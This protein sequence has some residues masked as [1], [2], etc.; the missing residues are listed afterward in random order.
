MK[1]IRTFWF[2]TLDGCFGIV[3]GEDDVTG[4]RKAYCGVVAGDDEEADEARI[5]RGGSSINAHLLREAL[6]LLEPSDPAVEAGKTHE[7][8]ARQRR[9]R[10]LSTTETEILRMI[11]GGA[12][13]KEIVEAAHIAEGSVGVHTNRIYKKLKVANRT[14]AALEWHGLPISFEHD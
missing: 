13:N 11:A 1:K 6:N 2:N 9:L 5:M 8:V 4:K 7:E 10:S 3:V 14:Q 12:S